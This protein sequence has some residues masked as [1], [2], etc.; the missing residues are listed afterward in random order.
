[1]VARPA[2]QAIACTHGRRRVLSE[3]AFEGFSTYRVDCLAARHVTFL[4]LNRS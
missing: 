2:K 4:F 1:M 3:S